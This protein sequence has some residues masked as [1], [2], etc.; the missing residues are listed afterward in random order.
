MFIAAAGNQGWNHDVTSV[1]PC[2]Y[3]I[4]HVI[5]VGASTKDE[6]YAGFSDYSTTYVDVIAP[7]E[8]IAS[9]VNS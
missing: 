2:D 1:Y 8:S 5:C 6:T 7:G 9:T 4:A 3:A